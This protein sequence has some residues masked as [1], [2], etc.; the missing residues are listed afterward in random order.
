MRGA[1]PDR[2]RRA[3]PLAEIASWW[4]CSER[5]L[6]GEPRRDRHGRP[7]HDRGARPGRDPL[8]RRLA[9]D[10][11]G[12]QDQDRRG[13]RAARPRLR[14]RRCGLRGDLPDA[15][16]RAS[17]STRSWRAAHAAALR[18]GLR[19]GRGD[20]RRLGRPLQP[21]PAR[22]L[23]PAAAAGRPGVLRRDPLVHGLPHLLL[24]HVQRRRRSRSRSSTPTSSAASGS[25]PRST[26]FGPGRRPTRSPRCGRPPR[27]S[28][29]RARRAASASS[30][31]TA[32]ASG[33]TSRR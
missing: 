29:S 30:S 31:G 5:G 15:P 10:A 3:R 27:S 23:R 24:P 2:D 7:G 17:T 6:E 16:A 32:S 18:A 20:Q 13:D 22:L 14:D 28:G 12:A 25:T 8:H 11:R 9:G 19:A 33:C 26:S 21:A 1:M 4:S